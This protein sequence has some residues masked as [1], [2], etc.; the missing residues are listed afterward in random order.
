MILG[1]LLCCGFPALMAV[2][3]TTLFCRRR[4]ARGKTA[5][6]AAAFAGG[7]SGAGFAML[8]LCGYFLSLP[9]FLHILVFVLPPSFVAAV[10]VVAY[11]RQRIKDDNH[12][13]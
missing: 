5:S 9:S 6:F 1:L 13:A 7:L 2:L 4:I 3:F 8:F 11:Y 10:L 12:V